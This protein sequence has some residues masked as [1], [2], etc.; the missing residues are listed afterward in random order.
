MTDSL[1]AKAGPAHA[2]PGVAARAAALQALLAV[3][4]KG[5]ALDRA[6][7]RA[8]D[9][10]SL[11]ARDRAFVRLLVATV[12]R[13]RGQI[14]WILDA[15]R[16]GGREIGPAR[17]L[18]VLRLGIAQIVYMGTPPYAAV[19]SALGL[20]E[21]P[22]ETKARGFVNALLRNA[23]RQ[24]ERFRGAPE[25]G[26]TAAGALMNLP[27]WLGDALRAAY[28]E[29]TT[30]EIARA[31]LREPPLDLTVRTEAGRWAEAL[32]ATVLP[33][34]SL[35]CS[36][37]GTIT[38]L[39]GFSEGSWWVQDAAAALPA[40]LLGGLEGKAVLDLCAAPGGKTAQLAAAG[41]AV[42]AVDRSE[43]RLE[44]LT[45]NLAR[46]RL[47]AE[48]VCADATGWSP[49]VRSPDRKF[50]AVLL[51][52]PCSATG[53]IRRHPDIPW[54]KGKED[55]SRLVALQD[56]LLRR[57]AQWLAPGG[58]L[59]WCTCSLLPEEGEQR[60]AALLSENKGLERAPIAPDEVGGLAEAVTAEG[61]VRTLPCHWSDIGGLDG[62]HI[63]RL[64]R[65]A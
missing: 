45:E 21:G 6:L 34:G 12:L 1:A 58:T 65:S 44:R 43:K 56:K 10:R 33:T 5:F 51:D 40:R 31:H 20:L 53:T 38:E 14:D 46:L 18:A 2:E 48:T 39:P 35:R 42:T 13:R 64:R 8:L 22:R 57:A 23:A 30:G 59:I 52:A 15:L 61:E 32:D 4:E 36:N 54:A 41:A 27:P 26:D 47:S 9:G 16:G 60:I 49:D 28:G 62:F 3:E 63:A 19:S 25:A 50:D 24:L 37:S 55:L 29:E 17:V 7:E 11:E